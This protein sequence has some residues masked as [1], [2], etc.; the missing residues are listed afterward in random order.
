MT[1][2]N[3]NPDSATATMTKHP[4]EANDSWDA[5]AERQSFPSS[6]TDTMDEK[7]ASLGKNGGRNLRRLHHNH[8]HEDAN[9]ES[10][11]DAFSLDNNNNEVTV[12]SKASKKK[13]EDTATTATNNN[14]DDLDPIQL[15]NIKTQHDL[16]VERKQ[17]EY[18]A[19]KIAKDAKKR[20]KRYEEL[21]RNPGI[22]KKSVHGLMVR[23]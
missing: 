15:E 6:A 8:Q 17:H 7:V 14:N 1:F 9:D 13:Y 23:Y 3:I 2:S 22:Q 18:D 16:K 12:K 19:H 4:I 10:S 21:Y 20:K 11:E 5:H